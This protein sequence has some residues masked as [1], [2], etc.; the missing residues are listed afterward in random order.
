M[1]EVALM[2]LVEPEVGDVAEGCQLV[3]R[4]LQVPHSLGWRR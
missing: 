4:C 2:I 1:Q 3:L